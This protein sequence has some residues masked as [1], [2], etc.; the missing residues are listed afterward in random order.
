M[1]LTEEWEKVGAGFGID[2]LVHVGAESINDVTEMATHAQEH[3]AI[4]LGVM[5]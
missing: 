1:S 5:P 2:Y 4:A 3:G